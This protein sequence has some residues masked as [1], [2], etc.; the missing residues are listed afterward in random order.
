MFTTGQKVKVLPPSYPNQVYTGEIL[1]K[2][3][4][5]Y[6]VKVI[7]NGFGFKEVYPANVIEAI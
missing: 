4:N 1:R 7:L 2:T 5:G 6:S 3:K